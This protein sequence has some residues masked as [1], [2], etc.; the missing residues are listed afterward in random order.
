MNKNLFKLLCS[1]RMHLV[2]AYCQQIKQNVET[3]K[4]P[5]VCNL[6]WV[7]I[8]GQDLVWSC[9]FW[10][11]AR[12]YWVELLVFWDL[13]FYNRMWRLLEIFIHLE[14]K[15]SYSLWEFEIVTLRFVTPHY[16][17]LRAINHSVTITILLHFFHWTFSLTIL[18]MAKRK[19]F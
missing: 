15:H 13:T 3:V 2:K 16:T 11:K 19:I 18:Q 8:R 7:S 17:L 1:K 5:V 6:S 12:L 9:P 10:F 4:L 14:H